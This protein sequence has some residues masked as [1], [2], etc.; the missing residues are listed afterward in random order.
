MKPERPVRILL[1]ALLACS[2]VAA[3]DTT[4]PL[5]AKAPALA[6]I[7]SARVPFIR[8]DGQLP[9]AE[10]R[11][12]AQT[13]AGTLFVTADDHLVYN[14]P[15]K[16]PRHRRAAWA[17][18][19][20]FVG[21]GTTAPRGVDASATR[22]SYFKGPDASRWRSD[23]ETYDTVSLGEIYPRIRVRLRAAGDSV[24]KLFSVA[25]G[26]DVEQIAIRLEGVEGVAIDA[27]RRLLLTTSLGEIAFT[28]PLAYQIVD[29][30]RRPVEV[31]YALA[32]DH[33][34]GFEVGDYDRSRELVID[35]MLASTYLG[36]HN[37]QPPGNYDDDIILGM[38]TDGG[39]VFVGGATQSPDFPV[40]LGYDEEL[41]NSYPDGFLTR[42]SGDLTTIVASTYIGTD[43]FDRVSDIGLD[44][45]GTIIAVGQAGWG[46]PVTDGAY[47]WQGSTPVGGGFVA[48]FSPD[49]ST[50]V[51]SSV[52]TPVDYPRRL[53]LGNGGIYFG[54]STNYPEFPI[55]PG[56]Y[57]STCCPVGSFGI[58]EHDGFAGKL[59]LDLSTLEAMTYLGGNAVSA[60]AVAPDGSVF[61]TDGFDYAITGYL[62]RFDAALTARPAY[63]TYYPGSESGSTRTYFN[64][65]A[66]AD[67][68]VVAVGQT[69]MN[70]L[71]AT[72]GAFDTT[73]GTDG[74]CDGVGPLLVPHSD[75]FVGIY[76]YDLG[77]PIALTYFGGSHHESIRSVALGA[78]GGVHV[79]GETTSV[80]FPTA[81]DGVDATCGTDGL[82][83][84]PD[85]YHPIS[86][87]FVARLSA[88]LSELDFG[89]YLGGSGEDRPTV[90][91]LDPS[92]LVYAAGYT[93]SVDFPTHEGAFDPTYN[94]GTSDAFISL[95]DTEAGG[96]IFADDF[97]RGDMSGWAAAVP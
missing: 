65:V 28:A 21:A 68:Y 17:F 7:A 74:L 67:G 52:P 97:E 38:V 93:D 1:A 22:V 88:D 49:L 25:P 96:M 73:C 2:T 48:R 61:I 66:A 16:T 36:G 27:D 23:L 62:A 42:M 3:A 24:E 94:G 31:A 50:L 9:Q 60:I 54:G 35:P 5:T 70:D 47:N 30:E 69:Y 89:T 72:P 80:D 14:L 64:D 10:V 84:A 91:A 40:H 82:C 53:A 18:R 20:S 55:T 81:G 90:V 59:S 39:D 92:D 12:Y 43:G 33:R 32:D 78:D 57:L 86:D 56:A 8:N 83:D 58:R 41:A 46:F 85:P 29:G 63:L 87:G 19:E 34:Y 26:G 75:G 11:F 51:A 79:A 15:Q 6:Q 71:P 95:F 45:A 37:P 77:D 4:T 76:S 13:F 44:A